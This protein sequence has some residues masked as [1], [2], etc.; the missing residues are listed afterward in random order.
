M[1]EQH[2]LAY[3][4]LRAFKAG[5]DA[6]EKYEK[7]WKA[8]REDRDMW[9]KKAE[10]LVE[11]LEQMKKSCQLT[12]DMFALAKKALANYRAGGGEHEPKD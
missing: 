4:Y 10:A 3:K 2:R 7:E 8:M 12:P 1:N 6:C 5:W 9:Q 11:A